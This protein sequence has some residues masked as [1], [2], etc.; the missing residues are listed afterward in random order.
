LLF[1]REHGRA[2]LF[3]QP[4]HLL[5]AMP[6]M[7]FEEH[8]LKV[9]PGD[10]L[11]VYTDGLTDRRNE[12]GDFYSIERIAALLEKSADRDVAGVYD[13]IYED[14]RNFNATDDFKDDIAFVVTRFQ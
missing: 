10:V 2:A 4:G 3:E 6:K 5:G 14:V 11:F 1:Q 9:A 13:A 8:A 12:A 7:S